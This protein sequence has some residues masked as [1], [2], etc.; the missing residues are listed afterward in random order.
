MRVGGSAAGTSPA[1][2]ALTGAGHR[3][4]NDVRSSSPGRQASGV[5]LPSAD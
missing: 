2:E 1:A 4:I 5:Q 3:N